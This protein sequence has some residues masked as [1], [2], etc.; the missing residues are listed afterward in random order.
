MEIKNPIV[1]TFVDDIK[2]MGLKRLAVIKQIKG[3]LAA[4]FD[5]IN[6]GPISFYLGLKIE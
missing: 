4:V 5:M 1:R 2:I 3:K 6:M